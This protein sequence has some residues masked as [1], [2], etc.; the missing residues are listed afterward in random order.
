MFH[1]GLWGRRVAGGGGR[2]TAGKFIAG[3]HVFSVLVFFQYA[4]ETPTP[5]LKNNQCR[6]IRKPL[7]LHSLHFQLGR[8]PASAL[9]REPRVTSHGG[10]ARPRGWGKQPRPQTLVR[11]FYVGGIRLPLPAAPSPREKSRQTSP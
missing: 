2:R 9:G 8:H 1:S 5:I 7:M 11:P 4:L 3:L 10:K 6:Y